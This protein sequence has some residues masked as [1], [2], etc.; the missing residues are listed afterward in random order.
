MESGTAAHWL[1]FL[2]KKTAID[3]NRPY[4]PW[5]DA[6]SLYHVLSFFPFSSCF[7]PNEAAIKALQMSLPGDPLGGGKDEDVKLPG[8]GLS[9]N[10]LQ[11]RKTT[12]HSY[13][14][15]NRGMFL[16]PDNPH[17]S[18]HEEKY[19]KRF[20]GFSLCEE[21]AGI[22]PN[23]YEQNH[24]KKTKHL[25]S[26]CSM[27]FGPFTFMTNLISDSENRPINRTACDLVV[28]RGIG[29]SGPVNACCGEVRISGRCF[30][31]TSL[32]KS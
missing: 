19:R 24:S 31:S 23:P 8:Y 4:T 20:S 15:T 7:R 25:P 11:D 1:Y 16:Q 32:M 2:V 10:F 18:N 22:N 30:Y 17:E 29:H 9:F 13:K 28:R 5:A 3:R 12:G 21:L 27:R 14:R 26:P 6:V